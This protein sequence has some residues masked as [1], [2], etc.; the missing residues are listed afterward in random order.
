MSAQAAKSPQQSSDDDDGSSTEPYSMHVSAKYLELTKRKLGFTRLPHELHIPEGRRWGYGTPKSVLEP[1]VDFWLEQYDWRAQESYYN[2]NLPQYRTTIKAPLARETESASSAEP[3]LRIHF[4][5]KQ[6]RLG[7]ITPPRTSDVKVIPLLFCHDCPASSFLDVSAVIDALTRAGPEDGD[8]WS[9]SW[10]NGAGEE[11]RREKRTG[12]EGP[13]PARP[14]AFHV[15]A[16]SVPGTGFS[17]ASADEGF[18]VAQTA[19]VFDALMKRLG[20]ERYVAFGAGWGFAVCRDLALRHGPE[21]CVAIHTANPASFFPPP[22]LRT[23]PGAWLRYHAARLTGARVPALT[24]GYLPEDF[25]APAAPGRSRLPDEEVPPAG[26]D[27]G[28]EQREGGVA[29]I[30]RPQTAAGCPGRRLG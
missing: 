21:S 8:G 3:A 27:E 11:E 15:V 19:D 23:A 28:H 1:L 24:F 16:P 13:A 4:V 7:D 2:S 18:G 5:H 12:T 29:C 26:V 14:I 10:A 25:G 6:C 9:A 20:Y 17:D 22:S 30:S